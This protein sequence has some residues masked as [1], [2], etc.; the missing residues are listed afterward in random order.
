MSEPIYDMFSYE[1]QEDPY[2]TY[3]ELLDRHP[4]YHNPGRG[5]WA[6]SRF[7]DVQAAFRD[8]RTFSSGEGVNFDDMRSVT[9]P[10]M[11]DMDPPRHDDLRDIVKTA[12]APKQIAALEPRIS[13]Y[14]TQLCAGLL[15]TG[16]ADLARGLAKR[17][18]V[19]VICHILGLP[20]EDEIMLK[21]WSDAILERAPDDHRLPPRALA[22]ADEMREYFRGALAERQA[23]PRDDLMTR[24]VEA[25]IN[26]QPLAEAE[27]LGFCFILFEAG[28][29]TTTSL[30]ANGLLVLSRYPEQR[31]WLADNLEQQLAR[32]IEELLRFEAPVQN[33]GRVT[34]CDVELYGQVIPRGS[35]VALLIGA[36]NRD[37]RVWEDPDLLDLARAPK[38]HL[39]FGEGI[40]HCIGAPLARLES[41]VALEHLLRHVPEYEVLSYE[42]FHDSNQRGL[43]SLVVCFG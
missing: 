19:M 31:A 5:F 9:G 15:E 16:T 36:A 26:G 3:R 30:L 24:L 41:K 10:H 34:V 14:V 13:H 2:P 17:L 29:S 7:A 42:R 18:P 21:R 1:I 4:L 23:R 25:R 43:A 39:S 12:F 6:L 27:L 35:R 40:H 32:A 22:A 11:L 28:N 20:L 33:I 38:R 37:E 8:W